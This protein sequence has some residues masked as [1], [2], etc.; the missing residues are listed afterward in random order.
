MSIVG[1]MGTITGPALGA[2]VL[3]AF[4]EGFRNVFQQSSL[5]IYG[6]VIVLVVRYAPDGLSGRV[7]RLYR[8]LPSWPSRSPSGT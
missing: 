3:L 8:R 2:L 4:Q 1:G 5:L 7:L 6:I